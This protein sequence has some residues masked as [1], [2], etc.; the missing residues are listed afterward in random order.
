MKA[1]EANLLKFL[2][3]S[4]PWAWFD[5]SLKNNRVQM[6]KTMSDQQAKLSS[7]YIHPDFA[8][9]SLSTFPIARPS[10]SM[11]LSLNLPSKRPRRDLS[12]DRICSVRALVRTPIEGIETKIGNWSV[13]GVVVKG[14]MTTVPRR[15]FMSVSD[16]MAQGRVFACSRP[17]TGSS[18][19]Q[20]TSPRRYAGFMPCVTLAICSRSV[21]LA[22]WQPLAK[23]FL[24]QN[25]DPNRQPTRLNRHPAT[26]AFLSPLRGELLPSGLA[27]HTPLPAQRLL[28]PSLA[29]ANRP[30][31]GCVFAVGRHGRAWLPSLQVDAAEPAS[32]EVFEW[33]A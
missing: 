20:Y 11:S 1:T 9:Q 21:R 31:I 7:I 3:K 33:L 19:V 30:S 12:T 15:W 29:A 6:T 2:K 14:T 23:R 10:S 22:R 13:K 28:F 24:H 16:M 4:P 27:P 17:T 25:Q 8:D 5:R 32:V 18:C 26:L